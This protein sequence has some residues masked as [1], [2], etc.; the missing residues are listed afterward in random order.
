MINNKLISTL[1]YMKYFLCSNKNKSR[2]IKLTPKLTSMDLRVLVLKYFTYYH[3][4]SFDCLN[5]CT[6]VNKYLHFKYFYAIN[7]KAIFMFGVHI[8]SPKTSYYSFLSNTHM[9]RYYFLESIRKKRLL[10]NYQM[11]KEFAASFENLPP[12]LSL[13]IS[14]HFSPFLSNTNSHIN[15]HWCQFH[16]RL[17]RTFFVQT[18]LF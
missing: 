5:N 15:S 11:S 17:T 8:S 1:S 7:Y 3:D 6:S 4:K 18:S 9:Q 2:L 13:S 14:L 16:Q 10:V 12:P